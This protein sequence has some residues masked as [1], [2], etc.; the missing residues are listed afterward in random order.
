[1]RDLCIGNG[2]DVL[3]RETAQKLAIASLTEVYVSIIPGYYIRTLSETEQQQKMKA[4]TKNVMQFEMIL[5][6]NYEKF[7]QIL[8]KNALS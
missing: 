5:I 2:I 4:E 6:S 7:V 3:V 1:M 8:E